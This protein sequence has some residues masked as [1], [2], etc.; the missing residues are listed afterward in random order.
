MPQNINPWMLHHIQARIG[1]FFFAALMIIWTMY[2]QWASNL[3]VFMTDQGISMTKYSLLWTL[4][5][6]LIVIIQLIITWINRYR[7]NLYLQVFLG[8]FTVGFSFVL[9]LF[10]KS[11]VWFVL[12]MTVLTI[13]EATAFPTM[14]AIVNELSPVNIKGKYQ[15]ILNAFSS[16]GKAIGPLFGGI[17]IELSSY[18]ILFVVCAVAVFAT[19]AVVFVVVKANQSRTVRY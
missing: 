17:L 15:G 4:N 5:G 1:I 11:Y 8:I 9:L 18:R 2:E 3:S 10:A 6:V 7:S 16:L 12:A 13:G 19:L 14:P